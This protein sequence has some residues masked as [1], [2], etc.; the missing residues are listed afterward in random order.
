[1]IWHQSYRADPKARDVADR[2]Y[3]RQKPGSPQFV[4]PGR[5]CVFYAETDSGRAVWVTSFPFAKY[6]KHQWGRSLDMLS[7]QERGRRDRIRDDPAGSSRHEV[8]PW[9]AAQPGHGHLHRPQKG[10]ANEAP[11]ERHMGP[12]IRKSRFSLCRKNKR[13][14]AGIPTAPGGYAPGRK[15]PPADLRKDGTE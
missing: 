12:H 6:V 15:C 13:R 4:P 14:I 1:M 8:G 7:I 11:R 3:N 2:H 9:R 5:C 10:E